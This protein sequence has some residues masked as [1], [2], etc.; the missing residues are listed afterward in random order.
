[1]GNANINETLSHFGVS[2]FYRAKFSITRDPVT[3]DQ[4]SQ[5]VDLRD[6]SL[7]DINPKE[8]PVDARIVL[9]NLEKARKTFVK[10]NA[11]GNK[12]VAG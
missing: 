6:D 5:L 8:N 10:E 11:S 1:M 4:F 9:E 7:F 12:L 2:T 3:D